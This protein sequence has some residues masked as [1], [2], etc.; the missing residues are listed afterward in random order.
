MTPT[1]AARRAKRYRLRLIANFL[2]AMDAWGTETVGEIIRRRMQR[3]SPQQ[4]PNPPPG[5][6][7]IRSGALARTVRRDKARYDGRVFKMALRAGASGVDYA[8]IHEMGGRAGLGHRSLIPPRPYMRPGVLD[9]MPT[10]K[11]DLERAAKQASRD[12]RFG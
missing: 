10:L 12:E 8:R 2:R 7:G 1:E 5:P 4:P 6:L 3:L 9:R 11:R